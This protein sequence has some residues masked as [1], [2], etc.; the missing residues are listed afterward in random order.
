MF[1]SSMRKKTGTLIHPVSMVN[2]FGEFLV[3][4]TDFPLSY[5]SLP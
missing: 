3:G 5:D 4:L 2:I 1:P